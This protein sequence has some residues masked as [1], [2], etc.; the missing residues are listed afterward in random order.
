MLEMNMEAIE[1][2]SELSG[3]SAFDAV[4]A[5][6]DADVDTMLILRLMTTK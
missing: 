5:Q 3:Q 6:V 1:A 4:A 2:G